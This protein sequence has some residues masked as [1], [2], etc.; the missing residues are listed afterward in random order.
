MGLVSPLTLTKNT[1]FGVC[2]CHWVHVHG[3]SCQNAVLGRVQGGLTRAA[4]R[5]PVLE[6]FS[7]SLHSSNCIPIVLFYFGRADDHCFAAIISRQFLNW[8]LESQLLAGN[9]LQER[10]CP[11]LQRNPKRVIL[12]GTLYAKA[13][14]GMLAFWEY[15]WLGNSS[16]Q[17]SSHL[18]EDCGQPW[19][20]PWLI[21]MRKLNRGWYFVWFEMIHFES[22]LP[23]VPLSG[24]AGGDG[25]KM[26][27]PT[28]FSSI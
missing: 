5:N 25:G 22:I 19:W 15:Q 20:L 4:A 18:S 24:K 2:L 23:D 27:G 10:C 13:C 1:I 9:S 21:P 14:R 28:Y 11:G 17:M 16:K 8:R 12:S 6:N 7:R 3:D 26:R